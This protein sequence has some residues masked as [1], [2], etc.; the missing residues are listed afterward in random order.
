MNVLLLSL[1]LL[2]NPHD[3]P[4][5]PE[6]ATLISVKYGFCDQTVVF[7]SVYDLDGDQT[8]GEVVRYDLVGDQPIAQ[9]YFNSSGSVGVAYVRTKIGVVKLSGE[10][11]KK[12]YPN[13]VCEVVDALEDKGS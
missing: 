2:A 6:S 9:L 4:P 10:E 11:I 1:L 12:R 13:S 3:F 8:T 7:Q 5:V